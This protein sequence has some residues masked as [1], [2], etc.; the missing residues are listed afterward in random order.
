MLNHL[1]RAILVE[2]AT[3]KLVK[4]YGVTAKQMILHSLIAYIDWLNRQT[5][6]ANEFLVDF[7]FS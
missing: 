1:V 3:N 2:M 7:F 5:T 4:T 6:I